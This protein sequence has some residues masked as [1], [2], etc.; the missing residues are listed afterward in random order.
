M[1]F[2]SSYYILNVGQF[3]DH[4]AKKKKNVPQQNVTSATDKYNIHYWKYNIC[5][6]FLC[7]S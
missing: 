1:L 5:Y 4:M 2:I 3:L 6:R 7:M